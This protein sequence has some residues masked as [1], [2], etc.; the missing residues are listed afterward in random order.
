[1]SGP[2]RVTGMSGAG[3]DFLVV[4]PDDAARLGDDRAGWARSVCTRG[5][6]LGADGVV[7]VE[8]Q[9]TD[10]IG[11]GFVN[12][13]GSSAF[14]GNGSRCA[15]RYAHLEGLAGPHMVLD[16]DAG[17]IPAEVTDTVVRLELPAPTDHGDREAVCAGVRHLG[18]FLTAGIPHFVLFVEDP[19][20][21]PL[22]VW[23][24]ALRRHAVFGAQGTNVNLAAL[25][26][27]GLRLR[28]WERG[29][30]RETLCC[31]SGAVAAAL[32]A[33]LRGAPWRLEVR[34]ASGIPV[35]VE[36][37]GSAAAPEHAILEGEARVLFRGEVDPEA[38]EWPG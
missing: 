11:V 13:D 1:M 34:P 10:R 35:H 22:D 23:G 8:V 24:P 19:I 21:A 15:A 2:V 37:P 9:G 32:A 20:A 38:W 5:L 29:V 17:A 26:G 12:P 30:E 4:G 31:G 16:T 3:N 18:R 14:C 27:A 7:F 36:L 33:R 28:T 6:S 25:D